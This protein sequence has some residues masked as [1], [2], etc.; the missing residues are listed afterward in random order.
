MDKVLPL[1]AAAAKTLDNI[2]KDD[3]TTLKSF[4]K[5]PEAAGFVMEGMCYVFDEDQHV[6]MV[7]VAPGSMEKKKDFWEYAKKKLLT[8]KL[9]TRVKEFREDKIKAIP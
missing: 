7:P 5:P 2:T 3:M 9:I 1:L 8:D 6:K 4:T